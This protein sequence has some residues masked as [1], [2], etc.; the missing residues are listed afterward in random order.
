MGPTQP[1][2][3]YLYAGT[4]FGRTVNGLPP[5]GSEFSQ[6]SLFNLLDQAGVSWKVYSSQIAYVNFFAYVRS[7]S[8]G[9]VSTIAQYYTDAAQGQ[10]PQVAFIDPFSAAP[11]TCRATS[12]R[13][14]MCRPARSLSRK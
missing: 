12:T 11:E 3:F 13:P 8:A 6:P 4:S 2:R 10:L 5:S 1:N 14:R 7:H 9:H